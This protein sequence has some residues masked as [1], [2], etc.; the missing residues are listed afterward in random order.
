MDI[1]PDKIVS[2]QLVSER[3]GMD[4]EKNKALMPQDKFS[5]ESQERV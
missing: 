1:T 5:V 2:K 4:A 3:N